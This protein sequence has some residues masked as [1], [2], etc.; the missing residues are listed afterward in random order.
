MNNIAELKAKIDILTYLIKIAENT[1][2]SEVWRALFGE[3]H[4]NFDKDLMEKEAA[5][6]ETKLSQ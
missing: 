5:K 3:L 6:G 4:D 2:G 1:T